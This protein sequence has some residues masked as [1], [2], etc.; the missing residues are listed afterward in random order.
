MKKLAGFLLIW[1][2]LWLPLQSSGQTDPGQACRVEDGR[3]IFTLDTRW[4]ATQLA[5]MRL[6]F[7][8][9]SA[10][11]EAAVSG[12]LSAD[13]QKAGWSLKKLDTRTVELSKPLVSASAST[14]D[15]REVT[16]LDDRWMGPSGIIQRESVPYGVN[17]FTRFDVFNYRNGLARFFLPGNLGAK[18]VYLSGSFNAWSTSRTPMQKTD[19]GWIA[20]ARLKP[21]KYTYKYIVDGRWTRDPFNRQKEDDLNGNFNSIVFCYNYTFYLRGYPGANGVWVAGSFNGW[22]STELRM[23]RV[24]GGWIRAMYL[25]EGT[26]A[27]KFIIDRTWTLD[28]ENRIARNDGSGNLNNYV[29]IGDTLY[30]RLAGFPEA[31]HIFLAGSFNGWNDGEL[32]LTRVDGGWEIPYVLAPGNYEYKFIRDGKWMTDPDNPYT[33]G[34]GDLLNSFI[35]V[36]PNHLFVLDTF[37]NA[38]TVILSGIFNGW[39]T[40]DYRM[41]IQKNKWTFPMHLPPGKQTYKFI[42]DGRW[43]TDPGNPLWE[44]NE[45]GT[46]NSVLWIDL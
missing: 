11:L 39:S 13:A 22:N 36:K 7:D 28:P 45:Y 12:T 31:K 23:Q 41:V 30:F 18:Q 14:P 15:R 16:M 26:H 6:M 37:L 38:R 32:E 44:E 1:A 3:L 19:S 21:G 2:S 46:G 27:Y 17:M 24:S 29:S 20:T 40:S 42:V 5:R 10:L 4:N 35:T 43:I 34:A 33:T 9:D 25:R 8:L